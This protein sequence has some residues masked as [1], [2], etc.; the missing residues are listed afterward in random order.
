MPVML[1]LRRLKQKDY[2]LDAS[3]AYM[4]RWRIA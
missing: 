2:E 1:V 4:G 3:P